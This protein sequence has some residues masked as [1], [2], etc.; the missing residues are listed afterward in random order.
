MALPDYTK[1]SVGTQI[2]FADHAGDFSPTAANS[3]EIS[4]PTDVEMNPGALA[5]TS[6]YQ[7]AKAD[8]GATRPIAYEVLMAVELAA[9]PTAGTTID[10]YWSPS[11]SGTAGNGNLAGV[12][13][14]KGSYTGISSNA[15]AAIKQADYV[16]SLV[17]TADAT[18]TVQRGVVSPFFVPSGRYGSLVIHNQSGAAFHSDDAEF[19]V[20]FNPIEHSLED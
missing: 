6:Y 8:L 20:V 1:L 4:T 13:G 15:A 14:A 10:V 16:G 19:H 3:L 9:T 5:N 7:S 12:S 2:C 18:T 11:T 17:L